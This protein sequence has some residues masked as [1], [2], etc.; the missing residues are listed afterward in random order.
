MSTASVY[1]WGA[2]TVHSNGD[3]VGYGDFLVHFVPCPCVRTLRGHGYR[4]RLP[5]A[6]K[7]SSNAMIVLFQKSP[8]IFSVILDPAF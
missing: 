5:S 7:S 1:C 6:S 2:P 8:L 3:M 4:S